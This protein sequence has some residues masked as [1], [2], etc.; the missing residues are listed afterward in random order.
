MFSVSQDHRSQVI[1]EHICSY[2]YTRYI[3]CVT[4]PPSISKQKYHDHCF[5]NDQKVTNMKTNKHHMV[6]SNL[7]AK[8]KV[9]DPL[10][11]SSFQSESQFT[12]S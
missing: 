12:I 7:K 6:H 8:K 3:K 10:R 1:S 2:V 11:Y 9:P 5:K 4:L